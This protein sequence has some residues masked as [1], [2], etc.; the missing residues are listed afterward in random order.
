MSSIPKKVS[1]RLA[2]EV[3]KYQRILEGS[4]NKDVNEADTVTII[5]DILADVFGYDKYTEITREQAIRGTFCDLA[6]QL[7]GKT[8]FLIEAKAIGLELNE[9]HLRQAINYGANHGVRW[10]V[11]TNGVVWEVYHI[12]EQIPVEYDLVCKINFLE[13]NARKI[14]DQSQL[15]LL[16]KEG[17][18]KSAIENFHLHIQSVNK[19]MV[20][21]VILSDP[22]V[23]IIRREIK[24]I[25][26]GIKVT[27]EEIEEIIRTETLKRE[28]VDGDAAKEAEKRVKKSLQK[29]IKKA[30]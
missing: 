24:K 9:T 4:K 23:N 11:L 8:Q 19:F 25:A 26:D 17:V 22:I 14:D 15:F 3:K 27:N 16:C 1:D 29:I 6:I 13:I 21:A 12:R 28:V 7:N 5:T 18:Q 10:I 2:Q 20:A 30:A